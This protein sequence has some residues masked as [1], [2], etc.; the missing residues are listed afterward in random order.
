MGNIYYTTKVLGTKTGWFDKL[1]FGWLFIVIYLSLLIAPVL[2]FSDY[3]YFITRNPVKGAEFDLSFIVSQTI[4]ASKIDMDNEDLSVNQIENMNLSGLR[5]Q[6]LDV[7]N[8]LNHQELNQ[9][10]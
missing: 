6:T 2:I 5:T 1:L 8:E 4:N 9:S 3:G 7:T 10:A